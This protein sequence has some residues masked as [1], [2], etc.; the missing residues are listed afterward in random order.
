MSQENVEV[1][2][3]YLD[4]VSREPSE[5][6]G[7]FWEADGD[8]YPARKFPE[9]RPCHGRKEIVRFI[10]DYLAAWRITDTWSGTRGRLAMIAS[11]Y[12]DAYG[13]RGAGAAWRW[14]TTSTGATG[15]GMDD[16]SGLRIT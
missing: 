5:R 13:Q 15:S 14:T 1:V 6:V 10:T 16:S 4:E 3:R 2:R 7:E 8:Y 12:M 11:L 9:A